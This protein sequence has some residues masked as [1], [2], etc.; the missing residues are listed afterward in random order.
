[1][2][3]APLDFLTGTTCQLVPG[4]APWGPGWYLIADNTRVEAGPF[5]TDV[6]AKEGAEWLE[7]HALGV[8]PAPYVPR[9]SAHGL[10][11]GSRVR[12]RRRKPG[13]TDS[14]ELGMCG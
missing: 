11:I 4:T 8:H 5:L 1:M 13:D 2:S 9:W 3:L 12:E 7:D 10:L 14:Q 6:A